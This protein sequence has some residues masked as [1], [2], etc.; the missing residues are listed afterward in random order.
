[1]KE[2]SLQ[3]F[4]LYII[5]P[6]IALL[7]G[8]AAYQLNR[9]LK[10]LSTKKILITMLVST[11]ALGIPGLLGWL[12]YDFMPYVYI[13]LGIIY[14]ILGVYAIILIRHILPSARHEEYRY[15]IV[16]LVIQLIM[17]AALFSLLFN[18]CNELQYG[19]WAW[20]CLIPYLLP[21]LYRQTYYS[22]LDIPLEIHQVWM[23]NQ[24]KVVNPYYFDDSHEP[25]WIDMCKQSDDH[26][27]N[28]IGARFRGDQI[29]GEW[30]QHVI[31]DNNLKKPEDP[32]QYYDD[33]KP[34]GWIFYVKP[35][36]FLPKRYIDPNETISRCRLKSSDIITARRVI[37]M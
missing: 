8:I 7:T 12:D 24:D 13:V 25:I 23:Y 20:T 21:S 15:E 5:F 19:L 17:G 27:L 30:F 2:L 29:F 14:F 22:Y 28:R 10:L 32:I 3:F 26:T 16:F 37:K 18:L 9:Y 31:E 6:V 35:S 36:I 34:F 11:L 33:T 1:M 4:V